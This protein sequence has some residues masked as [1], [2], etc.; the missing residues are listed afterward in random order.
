M[1]WWLYVSV[2][3]ASLVHVAI[4]VCRVLHILVQGVALITSNYKGATTVKHPL[5]LSTCCLLSLP[6]YLLINST[7]RLYIRKAIN[8]KQ[9]GSVVLVPVKS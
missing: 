1:V 2:C 9:G 5:T 3:L 8:I 6:Q 7:V 4:P